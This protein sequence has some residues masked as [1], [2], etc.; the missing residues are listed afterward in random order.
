MVTGIKC[1]ESQLFIYAD[2]LTPR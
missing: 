1:H 2:M